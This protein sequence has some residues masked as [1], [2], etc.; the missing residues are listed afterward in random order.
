MREIFILHFQINEGP[1]PLPKLGRD[2][3]YFL[4]AFLTDQ[5]V[6]ERSMCNGPRDVPEIRSNDSL[7]YV[8]RFEG[9]FYFSLLFIHYILFWVLL[10]IW[11]LVPFAV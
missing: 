11:L 9:K 6:Y 5:Y 2:S 8:R 1:V 3:G 7:I 4:I 10:V